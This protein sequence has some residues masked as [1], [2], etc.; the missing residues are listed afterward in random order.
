[1]LR[2]FDLANATSEDNQIGEDEEVE[3]ELDRLARPLYQLAHIALLRKHV[4]G[5]GA[6]RDNGRRDLGG[7]GK[8]QRQAIGADARIE[9]GSD[10]NENA[11][12]QNAELEDCARPFVENT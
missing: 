12:D 3:I 6:E 10:R 9:G 11:A 1:M 7:G 8:E 4:G 5:L 2:R